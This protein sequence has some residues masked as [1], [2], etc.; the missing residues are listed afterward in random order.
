MRATGSPVM[1]PTTEARSQCARGDL[2]AAATVEQRYLHQR[3]RALFPRGRGKGR[4][5]A[6]AGAAWMW[7]VGDGALWPLTPF[8]SAPPEDKVNVHARLLDDVFTDV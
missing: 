2:D 3:E 4:P 5:T 6:A 7:I 8:A 1:S